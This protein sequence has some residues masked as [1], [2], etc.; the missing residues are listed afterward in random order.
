MYKD[1]FEEYH[2]C[3]VFE[4]EFGFSSYNISDNIL[5]IHDVFVKKDYRKSGKMAIIADKIIE[6]AKK[7]NC[8]KVIGFV[9]YPS[10]YPE[11]SLKAQIKYGFKIKSVTDGCI[12][13]EMEI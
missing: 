11:Y 9:N 5:Y 1:W 10:K 6:I 4:C 3:Y 12:T 2:N 7:Q 13:L 8:K